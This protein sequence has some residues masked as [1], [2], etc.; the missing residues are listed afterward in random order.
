MAKKLID[1]VLSSPEMF[2]GVYVTEVSIKTVP[3]FNNKAK[4][5]V[6][7]PVFIK[8]T[9]DDK[10]MHYTFAD[11]EANALMTETLQT[12]LAK[13][14]L[15]VDNVNVSFDTEYFGAKTRLINYNGIKNRTNQCPIVIKGT[16]EQ[17]AFAWL[18]GIGN[19]TGIGFGALK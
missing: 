3:Q 1:G 17:I 10:E 12:K 18:V 13:A 8:R 5:L 15:A 7:S 16:P 6:A 2:N 19:S 9:V 14:G 4:F 11:Q